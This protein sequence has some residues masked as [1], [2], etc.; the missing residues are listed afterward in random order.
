MSKRSL[1]ITAAI[2]LAAIITSFA[3]AQGRPKGEILQ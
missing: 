3:V 2:A 1:F